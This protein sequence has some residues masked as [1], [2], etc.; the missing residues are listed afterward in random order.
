MSKR[1][2]RIFSFWPMHGTTS[3]VHAAGIY[4]RMAQQEPSISTP[5]IM[6]IG[7]HRIP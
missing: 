4:M 6:S 3:D 7:S 2:G 5:E 1:L